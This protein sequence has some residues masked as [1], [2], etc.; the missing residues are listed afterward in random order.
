[1]NQV[2]PKSVSR[3]RV[4]LFDRLII[5]YCLLMAV[6]VAAVGRP[7]EFY[8]DEIIFYCAMA[9]IAAL[10]VRYVDEEK[11]VVGNEEG[12]IFKQIFTNHVITKT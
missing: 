7:V 6:L 10:I 8:Y 9:G 11:R 2:D 1:M 12:N 5:G 3:I 4:Y